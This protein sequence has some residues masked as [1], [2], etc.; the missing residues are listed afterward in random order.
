MADTA[1]EIAMAVP[2]RKARTS[3]KALQL[4][5]SSTNEANILAGQNSE[6]SP[7]S[8][9]AVS[10]DAGKENHG[11]LSQPRSGKKKS[12]RAQKGKQSKQS[13]SF[14][15]DLQ[16]MQEKLEQ[17][18]LE[19]ERTEELLKARD[20]MLQIKEEELETRGREQEK[21]LMELKKLQKLK[22]FKP[23]VVRFLDY[24]LPLFFFFFLF[25]SCVWCIRKL[26]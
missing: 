17:L 15:R 2:V 14:E 22:E 20:E 26:N 12:K 11:S 8:V 10:E 13:Q 6:S 7:A 25:P 16:E 21:L 9:P 4:K 19:K 18:R 23:N 5:S 1:V 24:F 3:R